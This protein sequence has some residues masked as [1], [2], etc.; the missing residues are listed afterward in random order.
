VA[1]KGAALALGCPSP[2][3]FKRRADATTLALEEFDLTKTDFV[4]EAFE[5]GRGGLSPTRLRHA[6][7]R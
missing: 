3:T 7:S 1:L 2:T 4:S 6:F 5:M